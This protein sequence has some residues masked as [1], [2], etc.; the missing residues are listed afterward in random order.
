MIVLVVGLSRLIGQPEV[1]ER[2]LEGVPTERDRGKIQES[3]SEGGR[4]EDLDGRLGRLTYA[5]K[6]ECGFDVQNIDECQAQ[7]E[8]VIYLNENV[9]DFEADFVLKEENTNFIM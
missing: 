4:D 5:A 7:Q 1:D 2:K 3:L 8:K 9:T 6:N